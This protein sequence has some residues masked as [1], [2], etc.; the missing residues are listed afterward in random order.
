MGGS[1]PTS[2]TWFLEFSGVLN[3][4]GISIGAAIFAQHTSVTERTTDHATRSVT[5]GH[6]YVHSTAMWPKKG[7]SK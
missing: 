4:N 6:I 1:G 3:P 2:D 7:N 5:I